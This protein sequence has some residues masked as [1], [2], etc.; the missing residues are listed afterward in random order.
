MKNQNGF[1]QAP[2]RVFDHKEL[3]QSEK[4]VII[5]LYKC[6][7]T[8]TGLCNPSYENIASSCGIERRTVIRAIN[9]LTKYGVEKIRTGRSNHYTLP[10][11]M[12]FE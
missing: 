3:S 8:N 5:Y 10:D 2:N 6:R 4:L 12:V 9:K 7:N 1:F 11:M